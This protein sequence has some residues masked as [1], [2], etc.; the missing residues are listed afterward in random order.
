VNATFIDALLQE[1]K[2]LA[3][4]GDHLNVIQLYGCFTK[5]LVSQNFACVFV[6]YCVNGDLKQWLEKNAYKYSKFVEAQYSMFALLKQR[7][8]DH[9]RE[10]TKKKTAD[11][12]ID[13]TAFNNDDL[14]FMAY[15]IAKGM[16][17]LAE[18]KFLHKDLAAR[19]IL[20]TEN[21]A[22]KIS[23]FGLA[24]E[25]KF[26]GQNYFGAATNVIIH[27]RHITLLDHLFSS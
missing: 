23:D 10:N 4:I 27:Y 25:A 22:C 18:K 2:I 19:N 1:L 24:D 21:F 16:A 14:T 11:H 9:L 7:E 8:L 5:E 15:Q 20:L 6:E 17:Y 26:S 12:V 3:Y 13:V